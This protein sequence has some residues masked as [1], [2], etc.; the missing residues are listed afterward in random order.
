MTKLK[1]LNW[2]DKAM[3]SSLPGIWKELLIRLY[4]MD[5]QTANSKPP[6]FFWVES[7]RK[8]ENSGRLKK[9]SGLSHVSDRAI[10]SL[11]LLKIFKESILFLR[12]WQFHWRILKGWSWDK[13]ELW[14]WVML[15]DGGRR[16]EWAE[17]IKKDFNDLYDR[18]WNT[19]R[20][21]EGG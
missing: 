4:G 18:E 8:R 10:M 20:Y 16:V 17:K 7:W 6:E 5:L 12:E 3:L 14:G 19:R 1:L 11:S 9:Y 15:N 13:L 21:E 2:I